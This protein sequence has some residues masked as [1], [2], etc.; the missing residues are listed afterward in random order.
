MHQ[1]TINNAFSATKKMQNTTMKVKYLTMLIFYF[2]KKQN[3]F[4]TEISNE[5]LYAMIQSY[6]NIKEALDKISCELI[7][8]R[9]EQ[10][11]YM[12]Q[13]HLQKTVVLIHE[14][15]FVHR[16]IQKFQKQSQVDNQKEQAHQ[17]NISS[18]PR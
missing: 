17:K 5:Y 18:H 16:K 4:P 10:Q 1:T 13:V 15:T 9:Q 11:K 3:N 2:H 6:R 7:A 8:L 14:F 12:C